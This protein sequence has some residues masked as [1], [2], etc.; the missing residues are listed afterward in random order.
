VIRGEGPLQGSG[1][2]NPGAERHATFFA[3]LRWWRRYSSRL[4]EAGDAANHAQSEK[5]AFIGKGLCSNLVLR[6][7]E[8]SSFR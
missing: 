2:P 5:S 7:I 3:F 8:Q 4:Q 1:D 6:N